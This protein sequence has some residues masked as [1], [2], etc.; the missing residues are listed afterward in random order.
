M[1]IHTEN[2]ILSLE[3]TNIYLAYAKKLGF[4]KYNSYLYS[5]S[6]QHLYN[7]ISIFFLLFPTN[8]IRKASMSS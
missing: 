8:E 2:V 1:N 6:L 4:S 7:S 3:P 5:T